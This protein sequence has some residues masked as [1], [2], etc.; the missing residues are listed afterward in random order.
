MSVSKLDSSTSNPVP[1]VTAEENE[2]AQLQVRT[3]VHTVSVRGSWYNLKVPLTLPFT[4]NSRELAIRLV[5]SHKL[6]CHLEDELC[7]KLE[8]FG[9]RETLKYLDE[10]GERHQYSGSVLAEVPY[11]YARQCVYMYIILCNV[12]QCCNVR[13][14]LI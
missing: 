14:D 2:D 4:G 5:N 3:F 11:A 12:R 9:Y 13:Y 1:R 8:E 7:V 6:P 10:Q